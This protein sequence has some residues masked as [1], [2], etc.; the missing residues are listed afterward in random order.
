MG[1]KDQFLHGTHQNLAFFT[2]KCFTLQSQLANAL[3]SV[4]TPLTPHAVTQLQEEVTLATV[5]VKAE[6]YNNYFCV[7]GLLLKQIHI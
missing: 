4:V 5:L 7:I 2:S 1:E 3:P 6:D